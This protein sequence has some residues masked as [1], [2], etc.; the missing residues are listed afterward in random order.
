M[1][2]SSVVGTA[3]GIVSPIQQRSLDRLPTGHAVVA[4]RDFRLDR[5]PACA[6]RGTHGAIDGALRK[7]GDLRRAC[8]AMAGLRHLELPFR[9]GANARLAGSA[10]TTT[11]SSP[12]STIA[13]NKFQRCAGGTGRPKRAVCNVSSLRRL[14]AARSGCISRDRHELTAAREFG[15]HSVEFPS[16][17]RSSKTLDGPPRRPVKLGSHGKLAGPFLCARHG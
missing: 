12:G 13:E 5:F 4:T 6:S 17:V 2:S 1:L 14:P 7:Y 15:R 11:T 10:R 9:L 8:C 16:L 3:A